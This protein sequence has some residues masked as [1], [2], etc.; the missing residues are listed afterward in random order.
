MNPY[1]EDN[2][3]ERPAMELLHSI[4]W[5]TLNCYDEKF[6]KDGTL[7]R[8]TPS[9]VVL[10]RQLREALIRLN[11]QMDRDA[12]DIAV[13]EITKDRSAMAP[14]RA[15][16]EIY[17]LLKDGVPVTYRD[18]YDEDVDGLVQVINWKEPSTSSS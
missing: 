13:E 15:N 14:V 17:K 5:D 6:G 10:V 9:E 1:T 11:P 3:V 7:G 8:E 2:L 4:G 12:I 16:A 18:D